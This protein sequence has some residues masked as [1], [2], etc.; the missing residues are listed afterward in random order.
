MNQPE[1]SMG[2]SD[3]YSMEDYLYSQ[4]SED[5]PQQEVDFHENLAEYLSESELYSFS[6]RTY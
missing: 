6:W 2:P 1:L 3:I 4:N 5:E